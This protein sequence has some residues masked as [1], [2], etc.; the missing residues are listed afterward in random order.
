V[1]QKTFTCIQNGRCGVAL[2]NRGIQEVEVSRI[3]GGSDI[4]LTLI[5]AVG[6]LSCGDLRWRHGHAGP[7]LE[8]PEAQSLGAHRFEYALTTYAGDWESAGLVQQAHRFAFPPLAATADTHPGPLAATGALLRC[9]N[10]RVVVSAVTPSR[11]RGAFLVRCYNASSRPQTCTLEFPSGG[12]SRTV[13]F[14]ERPVR[15]QTRRLPGGA[16]RLTL[17]PFE[18][19]TLQVRGAA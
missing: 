14:L 6:W 5:R 1:P 12:R 10:A 3:D 17:R 19:V 2:F 18:I 15:L 9:D 11:R 7:G 13:N 16:L 8:T 4:A